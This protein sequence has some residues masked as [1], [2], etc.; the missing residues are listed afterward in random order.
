MLPR[1]PL[2]IM[3]PQ[4]LSESPSHGPKMNQLPGSP[5]TAPSSAP[6]PPEAVYTSRTAKK[7]GLGKVEPCLK[8]V[9]GKQKEYGKE[10]K[11]SV[12]INVVLTSITAIL[13]ALG[14]V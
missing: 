8:T 6:N 13:S 9:N 3:T 10:N 7:Y 2:P 11:W 4:A 1:P 12:I 5:S 14:L